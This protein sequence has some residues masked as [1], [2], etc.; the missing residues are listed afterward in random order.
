MESLL[1]TDDRPPLPAAALNTRHVGPMPSPSLFAGASV[2]PT[3]QMASSVT[4]L[5]ALDELA[6]LPAEVNTARPQFAGLHTGM[7]GFTLA[8]ERFTPPQI[9]ELGAHAASAGF[10]LL[11]TSD[12]FQPAQADEAHSG[13]AWVSMAA[14]GAR[15]EETWMGTAV[16][17]PILRYHPSIVAEAFASL[18]H[19]Y[20]GRIFLGVGSGEAMNEQAAVGRW[21]GW[22]ER[23]DRLIEAMGVIRALWSGQPVSHHGAFYTV[24]ATLRDPPTLPIPL[25]AA[26]NGQKSMRLAGEHADGLITDALTWTQYRA[27]WEAG[28]RAAGKESARMPVMVEHYVVV[29]DDQIAA[30]VDNP[31]S[32][33][34]G[35]A[36]SDL[37]IGDPHVW[38]A[39]CTISRDPAVHLD[40]VRRL[41]DGGVSIVNIRAGQADQARVID[42]YAE[43]V[44]PQLRHST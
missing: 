27:E 19:L 12:H 28:A 38:A 41:H 6:T 20:P 3:P 43:H 29:G 9:V 2:A 17:C 37:E 15:A 4:E 34:E 36:G 33:H 25:L 31:G 32:A 8:H 16:T 44:I 13:Q 14:L 26:A 7:L 10:E 21:P 23:W 42:F 11:A 5:A 24:E 35:D 39:S 30:A 1:M 22:Q 18:S 40:A